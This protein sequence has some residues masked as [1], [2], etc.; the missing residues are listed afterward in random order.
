MQVKKFEARTMKEALEMVKTQLGPDAIILSA[1]DNNRSFGLVGEG[2][3]EITA[4][5][6]EETLHRKKFVES[7][8]NEKDRQRFQASPA[9]VQKTII[10]SMV[11]RHLNA[12]PKPVTRQRY[13]DI[14]ED[15]Q[16]IH[17]AM[18][19]QARYQPPQFQERQE[20][21]ATTRVKNAA[22]RAWSSFSNNTWQEETP[23]APAAR[24]IGPTT[25]NYASIQDSDRNLRPAQQ[26][27]YTTNER[28]FNSPPAT[29]V[30][31]PVE[32][33]EILQLKNEVA[34]LKD[35][36]TRFENMPQQFVSSFPGQ[37]Y[38]LPFELSFMFERLVQTGVSEDFAVDIL[39]QVQETV[40]VAKLKNKSLIEGWVAKHIL[41]TTRIETS[42]SEKIHVFMGGAGSGK[43]SQ[44]VKM[45]SDLVIN[46]GKKVA[47][48]TTDTFKV[49]AADQLRIYA[50][51]LNVPFAIIR[52]T[53]DWAKIIKF[54]AQVDT[55]L[56]DCPSFS[57]K[58]HEEIQ[59]LKDILPSKDL[60]C[61]YHFVVSSVAKDS[62]TEDLA[63]RY[64][65]IGFD[66]V[67]FTAVDQSIQHGTIYNFMK[68]HQCPIHSF[69]IGSRVPEDFEFATRER[70]LD[71]LMKITQNKYD[72]ASALR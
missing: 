60:N 17:Q 64:S 2:S 54:L 25:R 5:V 16:Q 36:L 43:T 23:A 65:M 26:H 49:G 53:E 67:I 9:K 14:D 69:G 41:E 4:A 62:D 58:N 24:S 68:R 61:R 70:V 19:G 27:N 29:Y 12:Q 46:Q 6:S 30:Q 44:L 33:A 20:D 8:I 38:G 15:Q 13:I 63:R 28:V 3:V 52:G 32:S 50:Q 22:Q 40:P 72:D 48:F 1:R 66:D 59:K 51:I 34:G 71:L 18:N 57:L 11:K 56:V 39:N 42:V 31:T 35:L 45:A 37:S 10:D 7:R 55:V 47:L 21:S